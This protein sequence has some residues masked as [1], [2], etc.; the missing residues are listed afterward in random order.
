MNSNRHSYRALLGASLVSLLISTAGAV[1]E[2]AAAGTQSQ[3]QAATPLM[4][5]WTKRMPQGWWLK[6]HEATLAALGRE[7]TQIVF[8]G[9]SITDGWD[10]EKGGLR[11]WGK[12]FEPLKSLNLGIN[13]D[14]TQ[15]VLWRLEHGAVDNLPSLKVAI[16]M[17][18][19]NNKGINRHKPEDI[20]KG[21]TA[22]CETLKAKAPQAKILLLGVF[23]RH[24]GRDK[25]DDVNK[26]ISKL[27]DGKRITYLNINDSL[28]NTKGAIKDRV[29]H[30]TEKG[31]NVWAT[32]MRATLKQLIPSAAKTWP[33]YKLETRA[34][35]DNGNER[36][37]IHTHTDPRIRHFGKVAIGAEY[38]D[39]AQ[40]IKKWAKSVSYK[41]FGSPTDQDLKTLTLLATELR[42][43]SKN[44]E[45]RESH[46]DGKHDCAIH[47]VPKSGFRQILNNAERNGNGFVTVWWNRQYELRKSVILIAS[48]IRQQ[49]R[50]CVIREEVT[51]SLGMLRENDEFRNSVFHPRTDV[52]SF[53]E[54]DAFTISTLYHDQIRAGMNIAAVSKV[55]EALMGTGAK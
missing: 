38:G 47:F 8:L 43:L 25:N 16:V 35:E 49:V 45:F 41:V 24:F 12:E 44:I 5:P 28:L 53:S 13:C 22:I 50:S 15:H 23:P 21:I 39:N 34:G 7:D 10:N 26:I 46:E 2:N 27:H 18:G 20:A 37:A 19:V 17:I 51:Q 32:Q 29:G 14:S 4:N 30:L 33:Q 3:C 31:Y 6:R 40:V 42:R 36:G 54:L 1:E 48:D 55:L 52:D 9:D 11:I